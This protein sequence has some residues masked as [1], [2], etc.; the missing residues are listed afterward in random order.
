MHN[1]PMFTIGGLL[2]TVLR[3]VRLCGAIGVCCQAGV[4]G[5]VEGIVKQVLVN[6]RGVCNNAGQGWEGM[7]SLST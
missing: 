3:T 6:V 5:C 4:S 2:H 7:H 1:S